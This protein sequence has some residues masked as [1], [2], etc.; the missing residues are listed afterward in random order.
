VD[1][2]VKAPSTRHRLSTDER[3]Q[4]LIEY[5]MIATFISLLACVA[6]A[7]LNAAVGSLYANTSNQVNRGAQFST[8]SSATTTTQDCP[9][10]QP[11][12]PACK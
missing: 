5:A 9:K 8:Q 4:D 2:P 11:D 6:A 3:G 1:P 12:N 7:A 10:D